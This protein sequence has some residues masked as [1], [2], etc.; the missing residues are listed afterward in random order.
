MSATSLQRVLGTVST[1]ERGGPLVLVTVGI[2]GNEPAGLHAMRR[3]LRDLERFGVA[4]EGRLAAFVGNRAGL[5]RNVR[6][7]DEDMN[8]LWSRERV[9]A[10]RGTDPELDNV[11]RAEQRELLELL[12]VELAAADGA[13]THLDLHSTSSEGPPF[14]VVAGPASSRIAARRLGVPT[15]LG[16]EP[17]VA[18]TLIEYVGASGHAAVVLEGGQ[19]DAPATIDNHESAVWIT[20]CGAGV[21]GERAV[22]GGIAR[23]RDRLAAAAAGLPPAIEVAHVH[24]LEPGEEFAMRPGYRNFQSVTRDELLAHQGPRLAREIR[25]PW[26]GVLVMP[27][28]QGQGLDGFFLGRADDAGPG[29]GPTLA[30]AT[31]TTLG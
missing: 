25:A 24:R 29:A 30:D 7:V 16:L 13:A 26:S 18:G 9:D 8:R 14:T 10:L 4:L 28:Y 1:G 22:P 23:H 2:H 21:V 20:L 27:R 15:L 6:Y 17:I 3:V 11:E 5:A 12:D 19:N 31:A